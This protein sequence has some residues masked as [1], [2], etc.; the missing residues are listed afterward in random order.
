M[1]YAVKSFNIRFVITQTLE[2]K[3]YH[4]FIL[5]ALNRRFLCDK[6]VHKVYNFH[7]F[8]LY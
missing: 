6:I 1:I 3:I 4:Y 8:D 5:N 7:Y 2:Y